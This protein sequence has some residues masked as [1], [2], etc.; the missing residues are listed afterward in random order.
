MTQDFRKNRG[1]AGR[2]FLTQL[3]RMDVLEWVARATDRYDREFASAIGSQSETRFYSSLMACIKVAAM[4]LRKWGMLEFDEQRIIDFG[5]AAAGG[6]KQQIGANRISPTDILAGF[7]NEHW[8]TCLSVMDSFDAR[9]P[10]EVNVRQ[11][12]RSGTLLMRHEEKPGVLM[13]D[14]RYLKNWC[15]KNKFMMRELQLGLT[16]LGVLRT[17]DA[18]KNL[19]AGTPYAAGGNTQCWLIDAHHP[20]VGGLPRVET[21]DGR[22]VG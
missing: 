3:V 10:T 9:K 14:R 13:I 1:N 5:L 22:R 12:P 6:M 4:L 17:P 15:V 18:R 19:G 20:A 21:V 16:K 2:L 8:H 7:I 11:A